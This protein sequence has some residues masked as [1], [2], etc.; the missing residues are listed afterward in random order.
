MY[1]LPKASG[2]HFPLPTGNVLIYWFC[3]IGL[4]DGSGLELMKAL[5]SMYNMRGIAMSGFGEPKDIEACRAAGFS[6]HVLKPTTFEHI[7]DV[8]QIHLIPPFMPAMTI[9]AL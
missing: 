6:A 1:A 7:K 5:W 4:P 3:D 9:N 2:Q 8:I